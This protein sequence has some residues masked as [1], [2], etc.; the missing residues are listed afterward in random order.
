MYGERKSEEIKEPSEETKKPPLSFRLFVSL[1]LMKRLTNHHRVF[2]SPYLQQQDTLF[3]CVSRERG[4]TT[5][6][7]AAACCC[8]LLHAAAAAA[9]NCYFPHPALLTLLFARSGGPCLSIYLYN[10]LHTPRTCG[11]L[12]RTTH[13]ERTAAAF[14][15]STMDGGG[16]IFRYFHVSRHKYRG[17]AA[18]V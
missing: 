15:K 7:T 18:N 3:S 4:E 5:H 14:A 11:I 16:W 9:E 6:A 1:Q 12:P 17:A 8:M 10:G 13:H 2:L